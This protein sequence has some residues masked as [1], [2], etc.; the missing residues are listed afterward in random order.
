MQLVEQRLELLAAAP[1]GPTRRSRSACRPSDRR[2]PSTCATRREMRTKSLRI[3]SAAS[4]SMIRSPVRA[5]GEPRR[6][7]RRVEALQRAR[8]VDAL[9]AGGGQARARAMAV[10]ELE[11]RHRERAVDCRVEG[12]GDDHGKSPS[13]MMHGPGARTTVAVRRSRAAQPSAPASSGRVPSSVPPVPDL[14]PAE[15]L[16]ARDRAAR[17]RS[18]RRSARRAAARRARPARAASRA[19]SATARAAVR[20]RRPRVRLR[21][22]TSVS[23]RYCDDA[24]R[25]QPLQIGVALRTR[26]AAE[27]HRVDRVARGAAQPRP[28]TSRRRPCDRS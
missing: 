26:R 5:A 15:P 22:R 12:D 27:D 23:V 19:T 6:D 25:E 24:P 2:P 10:P 21:A 9:A 16:A 18:A 1:P 11:V 4:S 8:D 7:H 13:E 14:D 28:R 17:R 20:R 3:A